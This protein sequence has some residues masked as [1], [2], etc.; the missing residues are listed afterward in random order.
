MAPDVASAAPS[1]E[2]C[3]NEFESAIA[4]TLHLWQPLS[5]AVENHLGGGDGSDK[6]DWFGGA[7]AELFEESWIW[8]LAAP[9]SSAQ[10]EDLLMDAEARLIQI[11]DDEF[12][13]VVDDGSAYDIAKQIVDLWAQCRRGQFAN[14]A[15]LRRRWEASRGR[16]VSGLFQAA[17]TGN[18]D[19]EWGTDDD[20]DDDDDEDADEDDK[21]GGADVNMDEAPALVDREKKAA[22]EVDEDGF[23]TVTRKKR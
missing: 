11:M 22:P 14:V 21:D 20:D 17:R 19:D 16:S 6:R 13:T 4:M 12:D 18:D 8:T 2:T 9:P 23:T 5:F 15:D 1:R 7:V 10:A 3:Q